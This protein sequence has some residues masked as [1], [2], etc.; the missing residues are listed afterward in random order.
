MNFEEITLSEVSR[1]DKRQILCD[2]IVYAISRV[3]LEMEVEQWPRGL[4]VE[5]GIEEFVFNGDSF[6]AG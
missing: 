4:G 2:A 3:A 1:K 6:S 5:A